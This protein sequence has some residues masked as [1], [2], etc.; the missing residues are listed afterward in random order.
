MESKKMK[1]YVL[2]VMLFSLISHTSSAKK[3]LSNSQLFLVGG[4][5]ETCTSIAKKHC[6]N[7]GLAKIHSQKNIKTHNLYQI[8]KKTIKLVEGQW[9]KQAKVQMRK[10]V[11]ALLKQLYRHSHK[12]NISLNELKSLFIKYDKK[13]LIDKLNDHQYFTL[14]DLLEQP[15]LHAKTGQRLKE[16]VDLE[17][18]INHFSTDIYQQF[19][20][21]AKVISGHDKPDVIVLTASARDPFE[22]VDFYQS[23]FSQ[24]GAA[25]KWLPL[26]ATLNHLIHKSGT[27]TTVCNGIAKTRAAI[28]GSLNREFVYPDYTDQQMQAC[29]NPQ[30][31]IDAINSADGIFINGGDQSLTLKAFVD[32]DGEDSEIL[33]VIKRKLTQGSLI[34]G[35]TSAGTAVMSGGEF[36]TNSTVMITNGQSNTAIIRG[37]KKDLLPVEGCQKSHHC[38]DDLQNDDLSY[39]SVGGLGVFP[40]GILDTHFSERGRQ[41]RLAIL[42]TATKAKYAFGVDESTALIVEKMTNSRPKMSVIGQGGVFV[43]ENDNST[44]KIHYLTYGD[45]V[46]IT[47]NQLAASIAKW[48]DL[49]RQPITFSD[50][51][52]DIFH[53]DN[54]RIAIDLLCRGDNS[55]YKVEYQKDSHKIAV[56]VFKQDNQISS[57]GAI[58]VGEEIKTYCS[59]TNYKMLISIKP[60]D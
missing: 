8:N 49:E 16:T 54:F 44:S 18:S 19:V 27:R 28:Q 30:S 41:G 13:N 47:D 3:P 5:L 23:V 55:H 37:A 6:N 38:D 33:R 46:Q 11:L 34:L 53:D 2:I 7:D 40:W 36:M 29:L 20:A 26:D 12:S 50:N 39:N 31:V 4:G 56:N 1:R 22:A 35:G 24:A 21:R 10:G 52:D 51:T 25:A 14:L 9:A 57:I 15:V 43:I 32:N 45:R 60:I 58:K 48:K 42:T 17:S 59:Y